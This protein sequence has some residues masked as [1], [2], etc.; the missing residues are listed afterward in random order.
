MPLFVIYSALLL[1]F[2]GSFHCIG[3]CGPIA[4]SIS[5]RPGAGTSMVGKMGG[6]LSYFLGKT[7]T[8][9]ILGMI[10]GLFGQG[11]VLAGFQQALSV[12]MGSVMLLLVIISLVKTSWFHSNKAT[13]FLQNKLIPAFGYLL[14]KPG[15][16]TPFLLGLVNGLLPCGLVYIG[17]TAAVAT[18]HA[19]QASLYMLLFGA[20]TIPTMLAFT[21]FAGQLSFSWRTKLRQLTPVLMAIVGSILILRGLNLGIPYVSPLLDSL[22]ITGNRGSEGVECHP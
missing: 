2:A 5:G 16:F 9:G 15:S 3:M 11:L 4:L 6:Y 22:M 13:V 12:A 14:K 21:V 18:G 7:L 17:L 20:G 1:G 8:Y 19:L 10:F